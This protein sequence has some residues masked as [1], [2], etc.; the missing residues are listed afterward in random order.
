MRFHKLTMTM[1]M[2]TT[3]RRRRSEEE[4][5]TRRRCS[6]K[7]ESQRRSA[8]GARGLVGDRSAPSPSAPSA[9]QDH[10]SRQ[11]KK[12]KKKKQGAHVMPAPSP[13]VET[14]SCLTLDFNRKTDALT[15]VAVSNHDELMKQ[16]IRTRVREEAGK[17]GWGGR[18]DLGALGLHGPDA[19][20]HQTHTFS[21]VSH[22][23]LKERKDREQ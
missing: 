10:S 8:L 1:T 23:K 18:H 12:K 3:R 14:P 6:A 13:F 2:M 21:S 20:M 15:V 5:W 4:G 7:E 11:K 9:R 16:K 17:G 22:E 19:E